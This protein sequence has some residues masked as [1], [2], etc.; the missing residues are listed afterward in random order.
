[1]LKLLVREPDSTFY[2]RLVDAQIVWSSQV[3]VTETY[4]ALRRK[5][6]ERAITAAH[7]K[8]AWQQVESDL[9]GG[10]LNLVP[11][12]PPVLA[13]ANAILEACH[14]GVALRSL[15]AIHL[16]SARECRSWPLC[17][18]DQRMREAAAR[19]AIPLSPLPR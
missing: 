10:R 8:R 14:P 11:V 15:D 2:V 13:G 18:N 1:L 4:S 17:T 5:E 7:R 12:S 6:R 19:L 3:I 9:S 16:A